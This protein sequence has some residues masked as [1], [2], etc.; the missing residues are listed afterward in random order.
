MANRDYYEILGID[1][2]AD[3][4]TIKKVYR[5]LAMKYHPDRN[6]G[7]ANAEE[8]FKEIG[9]AYAVLS[10]PEKRARYDRYGTAGLG[11]GGF[12]GVDIDPFEIFRNFMG[13]FGFGDFFGGTGSDREQHSLRGR[14]LQINLKLTLEEIY[15][16]V[17]KKLRVSRFGVCDNCKGSGADPGSKPSTCS[18]CKGRGEV[19]QVT[20]SFLGQMVNI[21]TCPTCRGRGTVILNPCHYCRGEG[22]IRQDDPIEVTIP[23]GVSKGN[24]LTLRGEGHAGQFGGSPGDLLLVIDEKKH[25]VFERDGDNIYSVISISIPEAV[26][27]TEKDIPTLSGKVRMEIPAGI[28]SGKILRLRG[29]G[30]R[31]LNSSSQG[32]H[33]VRVDIWI[34]EKISPE[35]RE[36]F[37]ELASSERFKPPDSQEKTFFRKVKDAF[38]GNGE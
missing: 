6:K 31:R 2:N 11:G 30:M 10:D 32:D 17:T 34:P 3:T 16:G 15:E 9:E 4:E 22:R 29:K 21:T 23:A 7:D 14:D 8:R 35:E 1:R 27:G 38:F 5:K 13:G 12:G 18:T 20:R 36:L 26:L 25:P 33:L 19:R 24:I 37:M 28:Q